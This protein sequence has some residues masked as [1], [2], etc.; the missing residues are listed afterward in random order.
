M[1]RLL[2]P[3][4]VVTD[5]E[6]LHI[7]RSTTQAHWR[8][9]RTYGIVVG[10]LQDGR[11]AIMVYGEIHMR[12]FRGVALQRVPLRPPTDWR[13]EWTPDRLKKRI[14]QHRQKMAA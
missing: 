9:Y 6:G 4:V 3:R 10:H 1:N 11:L 5:G 13:R 14:R 8:Y 2:K 7:V 12:Y